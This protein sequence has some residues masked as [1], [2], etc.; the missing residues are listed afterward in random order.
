MLSRM[1]S[2]GPAGTTVGRI[3]NY[4]QQSEEM[5]LHQGLPFCLNIHADMNGQVMA[6]IGNVCV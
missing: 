6:I 1:E 2:Y 5:S 4:R 3:E